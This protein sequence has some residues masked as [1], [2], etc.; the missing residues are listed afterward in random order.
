MRARNQTLQSGLGQWGR[1]CKQ[2]GSAQQKCLPTPPIG[3]SV[4]EIEI[5]IGGFVFSIGGIGNT[6]HGFENTVP[7]LWKDCP[8]DRKS[9]AGGFLCFSRPRSEGPWTPKIARMAPPFAKR[10]F[11]NRRLTKKNAGFLKKYP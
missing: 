9:I 6:A 7:R 10:A 2:K 8:R 1:S 5:S 4:P 3:I 11:Q